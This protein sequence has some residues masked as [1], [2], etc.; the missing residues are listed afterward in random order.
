MIVLLRIISPL[1]FRLDLLPLAI[2]LESYSCPSLLSKL[3][4]LGDITS[5]SWLEISPEIPLALKN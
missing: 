2:Y 5:L 3:L 1:S 4:A